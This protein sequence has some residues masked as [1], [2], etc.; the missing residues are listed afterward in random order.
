MKYG[1]IKIK[2]NDIVKEKGI[3]NRQ[4]AFAAQMQRSQLKAYLDNNVT[5]F[6]ADVLA[7][8]CTVLDCQISDILEFIPPEN[9]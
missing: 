4:L 2:L 5:R 9:K 8:L 3:S 7:R 1:S 6:D